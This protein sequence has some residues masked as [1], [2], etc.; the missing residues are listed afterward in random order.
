MSFAM[1]RETIEHATVSLER[2]KVLCPHLASLLTLHECLHVAE[3][4]HTISCSG[5]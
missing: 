4:D 2:V 1:N 3:K 5:K